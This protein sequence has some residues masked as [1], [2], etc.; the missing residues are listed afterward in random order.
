MPKLV[1]DTSR[2]NTLPPSSPE[3]ILDGDGIP[4]EALAVMIGV[5]G[6]PLLRSARLVDITYTRSIPEQVVLMPNSERI[7]WTDD[8]RIP[9]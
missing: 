5:T 3:I 2:P 4:D 8:A 9:R 7:P 1:R 6:A